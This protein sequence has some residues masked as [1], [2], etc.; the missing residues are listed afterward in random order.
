VLFPPARLNGPELCRSLQKGGFF[1]RFL[2]TSHPTKRL[3]NRIGIAIV[4]LEV[5]PTLVL[6][7]DFKSSQFMN[8][9]VF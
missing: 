4:A 9:D 7:L 6:G 2:W 3:Q 8:Y 1:S 5:Y